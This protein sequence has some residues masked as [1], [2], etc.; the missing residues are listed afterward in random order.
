MSFKGKTYWVVGASAGLG[1]A[2]AYK[3]ANEG[4]HL[5]L[6]AR[7]ENALDSLLKALPN[8]TVLP[9]D[10]TDSVAVQQQAA[11]LPEIDGL[12]YVAGTYTPM[13]AA[14]WDTD[15][16]LDI[17]DVNF[18]GAIRVIGE[19]LPQF[20]HKDCGHIV[21]IGSLAAYQGLPGTLGYGSSKSA[22]MHLG[23]SLYSDL[24]NTNVK[25]Q[26]INPGYIA[27]RL[28][29]LNDFKMP[30]MMTPED[31]ASHVLSAMKSNR[32]RTAF[33][34]PFKWLFTLG[35]FLPFKLY[36]RLFG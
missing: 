34:A 25:V 6:S 4:A 36:A 13:N 24:K 18:S 32:F 14:N 2:L 16:I 31:A 11:L 30:Q 3:L 28:T 7:D 20:I 9:M 10:V 8:A 12:I 27:T 29:G 26:V 35:K 21:L 17:H 22:L 33:P 23:E 5:V 15:K 1:R 19:I